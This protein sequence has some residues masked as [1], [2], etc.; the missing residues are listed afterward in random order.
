MVELNFKEG[1]AIVKGLKSGSCAMTVKSESTAKTIA[2]TIK[3]LTERIKV[4]YKSIT[5]N[6]NIVVQNGDNVPWNDLYKVFDVEVEDGIS[7]PEDVTIS[8]SNQ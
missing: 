4:S 8:S 5:E 3:E 6:K 2:L 1:K 7:L